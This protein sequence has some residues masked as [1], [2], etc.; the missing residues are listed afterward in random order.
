MDFT[1]AMAEQG[2]IRRWERESWKTKGSSQ[3]NETE[4]RREILEVGEGPD[5]N[6]LLKVQVFKTDASSCWIDTIGEFYE[7]HS[8]VRQCGDL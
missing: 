6:I 5:A 7:P 4:K 3:Q 8:K 2:E 1:L